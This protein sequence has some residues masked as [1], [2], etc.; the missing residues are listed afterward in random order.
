MEIQPYYGD[1]PLVVSSVQIQV[2]P[3]DRKRARELLT[4]TADIIEVKDEPTYK[5]ATHA[6]GQLKGMLDEIDRGK[7]TVKSPFDKVIDMIRDKAQEIWEPVMNE[8]RRVQTILNGY[9]AILEAKRK[10]EERQRREE[11]RRIQQEHDRK[12]REAREA[13]VR[14]ENEARAAL[15]EVARQR[16]HAEAQTQ[17]LLAAQEQLAKELAVEAS[18]SLESNKRGL[19]PGG[20]VDHNYEFELTNIKET[21]Q[22]GCLHLI[23]WEI[24]HR[25][26]QDSCRKQLEIDPSSEPTLPGIK[27]TRKINVS[28]KAL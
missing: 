8:H 26:C 25:A 21:I 18:N 9:V 15:D 17:L 16:A 19:V 27:V 28:V 2:N 4:A 5:L 14:A 11:I 6:L 13:Q 7:K 3:A 1:E 24:D 10:E 23:R 12:I 20:R 22:A